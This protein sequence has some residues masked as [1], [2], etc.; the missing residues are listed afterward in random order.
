MALVRN[1]VKDIININSKIIIKI[2]I[3]VYFKIIAKK[4]T[5]FVISQIASQLGILLISK[6]RHII[7]FA[8]V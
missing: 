3:Q 4:S 2:L 8:K 1:I 7:S 5:I 6:K